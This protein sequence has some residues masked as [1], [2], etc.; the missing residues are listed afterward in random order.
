MRQKKKRK[1]EW[2]YNSE[3]QDSE[4]REVETDSYIF[5]ATDKIAIAR[6]YHESC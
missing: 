5:D 3:K 4:R 6:E 1:A 2:V